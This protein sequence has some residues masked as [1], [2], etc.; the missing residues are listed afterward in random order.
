[1]D[2]TFRGIRFNILHLRSSRRVQLWLQTRPGEPWEFGHSK[3]IPANMPPADAIGL[4]HDFIV[5]TCNHETYNRLLPE[6]A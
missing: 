3:P 5:G 4:M 1:M 6:E 2:F